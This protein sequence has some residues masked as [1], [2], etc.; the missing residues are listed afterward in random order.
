MA[1]HSNLNTIFRIRMREIMLTKKLFSFILF[2]ILSAGYSAVAMEQQQKDTDYWHNKLGCAPTLKFMLAYKL[3]SK[4]DSNRDNQNIPRELKELVNLIRQ[5][6]SLD[7]YN[8]CKVKPTLLNY[9]NSPDFELAQEDE[10]FSQT[11]AFVIR[12]NKTDLLKL[13]LK[14]NIDLNKA[15]ALYSHY[16]LRAAS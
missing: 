11:I 6:I 1:N 10:A 9:I 14:D 5:V 2:G 12:Q 16:I 15:A 8:N 3:A 7:D 13:L 4:E